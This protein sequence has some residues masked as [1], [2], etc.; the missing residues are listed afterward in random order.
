[1]DRPEPDLKSKNRPPQELPNRSPQ[2]AADLAVKTYRTIA[3][4][5]KKRWILIITLAAVILVGGLLWFFE[6]WRNS[7]INGI[8]DKMQMPAAQVVVAAVESSSIARNLS[9]IGSVQAIQQVV[10]ASEIGGKITKIYFEA[11]SFVEAGTPLIQI[12]DAQQ[13]AQLMGLTAQLRVAKLNLQRNK[14]LAENNFISQATV[15]NLQT[16]VD[17]AQAN[18]D[19]VQAVID[20]KLIRAPFNGQLGVRKVDLGQFVAAGTAMVSLTNLSS[21][22]INFTLPEQERSRLQVGQQLSVTSVATPGQKFIGRLT[23]IEPQIDQVSRQISVQGM[24]E[25]RERKLYPGMYVDVALGLSQNSQVLT[26]PETAVDYSLYGESVYRI[27][28]VQPDPK[29]AE[30][31]PKS[32]LASLHYK[33]ERVIVKTGD[34]VKGRVEIVS[35]L[36]VGDRVVAEGQNRIRDQATVTISTEASP[37]IAPTTPARP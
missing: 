16:Q 10:I 30:L 25:N 2:K 14:A 18:L 32:P 17:T 36:V 12:D 19:G 26:V 13:Q 20:Q 1:M 34:R 23:A 22:Y 31:D 6:H 24:I 7:M 28:A 11:G 35:G 15:D 37:L 33:A 21:V 5:K 8:F 9:G 4:D 3:S 29:V 27:V